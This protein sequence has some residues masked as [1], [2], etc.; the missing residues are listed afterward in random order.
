MKKRRF[1]WLL[2]LAL[3]TLLVAWGGKQERTAAAF[4]HSR[5]QFEQAA[6]QVLQQGSAQGVKCPKGVRSITLWG[7]SD[8]REPTVE[9][10]FGAGGWGSNTRY[11]GVNY[12]GNDIPVGFQAVR[13]EY[14]RKEGS[15]TRFYEVESDNTCYVERLEQ[16]WFYF[17]M[18]F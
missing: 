9:F 17:E 2:S 3:A 7:G 5:L 11:W 13:M 10:L 12:V 4:A 8:G 1:V 18:E 6:L 14:W 15:G 16:N